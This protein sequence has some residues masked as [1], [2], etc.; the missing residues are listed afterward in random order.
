MKKKW[1]A[2][3]AAVLLAG[4]GLWYGWNAYWAGH[5]RINGDSYSLDMKTLDLSG[6][7]NPEVDALCRLVSLESL[8]LR[9]TGLTVTDYER[10]HAALRACEIF[11]QVPFQGQYLEPDTE[12]LRITSLSEE[13]LRALAYLEDLKNVD[14]R[15]CQELDMLFQ[16][17]QM[18][19]GCR[20]DYLVALGEEKIPWDVKNLTVGN[21]D[22]AELAEKL[23]YLPLLQQLTLGV[24]DGEN[25]QIVQLV[26]TYPQIQFRWY[27][28]LCGRY[29]LNTVRELDLSGTQV[30]SVA[31]VE[32]A[33]RYFPNLERVVMC[34]CGLS[35][36]EMDALDRRHEQIRFIWSVDLG[37][38][39]LRTDAVYFAPNKYA[40]K[41][42]D[43]DIRDLQYCY[44][45]VCVDI[46]HMR[47]VTHC[48]WA[49][50][51]P[52]LKYLVIGDTNIRDLR[53]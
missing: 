49:A 10:L 8:D 21:V 34:G 48:Q 33:L 9:N 7:E 40:I 22:L 41:V 3:L 15:G 30:D 51:M 19:P 2:V 37:G 45:M 5:L 52:K 31:E 50:N 13:D 28:E 17:R 38:L 4:V 23:K 20:I 47:G 27:V 43:W 44:D 11:W 29:F 42:T 6:T 26:E 35:S 18:H 53:Q 36:E 24:T 25:D 12:S 32:N 1:I 39:L 14:A 16:L 46:G